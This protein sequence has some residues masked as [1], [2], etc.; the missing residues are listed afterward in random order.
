[1]AGRAQHRFARPRRRGGR[2]GPRRAARP[3]RHRRPAGRAMRPRLAHR[4][5]GVGGA[6]DPRRAEI[7]PP[8]G[9]ADSPSRPAARGCCTA[10]RAE[11]RQRLG[12]VQHALGQVGVQ[13]HAL[14]LAGAERPALVP[15][16]VR[17]S[18]DGRSRGRA[19]P[20]QRAHVAAGSPSRAPASA[21]RSATARGWPSVYGDLRST[22]FA[23]ASSAA[24]N[25]SP[26]STT[27][28]AGSASITASQAAT[29]VEAREDHLRPRRRAARPARDRTA[30]RRASVRAPSPRR[31]R[32][33]G[34]RP[35]RTRP[36]ARYARRSARRRPR[37]RPATPS[38]PPL[39]RAAERV[40]HLVG[41]RELLGRARGPCRRGGRSCR[42]PRGGR[43]A[44]TRARAGS[45]AAAGCPEPISRSA[46]PRPSAGCRSSWSYL[47]DFSAM[48]S[49]NHFACSWA[50]EWQ[51]TL[52]SSAV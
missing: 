10:M 28:S 7:A 20:A 11:R 31:R 49:P 50:S 33:R 1:M 52:T 36:A 21:A 30:C 8:G 3:R 40:E 46:R 26:D 22:K 4:L 5:V 32:R 38:V 25:C 34:A 2:P 48:S 39:V 24:S 29:L 14:P 45:D 12:L 43:T 35:R 16:R 51:P 9:R 47:P 27:A 41:Q 18:R 13:A 23:I 44:R 19:R 37:A 42:R 6:E 15:D 17:D